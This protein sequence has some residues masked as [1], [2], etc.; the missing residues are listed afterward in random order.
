MVENGTEQG[1]ERETIGIGDS[2]WGTG[3]REKREKQDVP[4]DLVSIPPSEGGMKRRRFWWARRTRVR[5]RRQEGEVSLF[6]GQ[7]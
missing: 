2:P 6:G 5:E 1:R 7:T 3:L 4:A